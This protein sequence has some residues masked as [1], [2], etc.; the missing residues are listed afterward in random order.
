MSSTYIDRSNSYAANQQSFGVNSVRTSQS[1]EKPNLKEMLAAS[2]N[3]SA[4]KTPELVKPNSEPAAIF[5]MSRNSSAV[6]NRA[7]GEKLQKE[8]VEKTEERAEENQEKME[9][10]GQK[11]TQ[12]MEMVDGNSLKFKKHDGSGEIVM[13]LVDKAT[14]EEVR[15]VPSELF[16]NIASRFKEFLEQNQ[17]SA[18]AKEVITKTLEKTTQKAKDER[19]QAYL[20]FNSSSAV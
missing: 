12:L 13:V 8:M 3:N 17:Q 15:Q 20:N 14:E 1:A 9:E 19:A 7:E 18:E 16:L 6:K 11:M 5:E 2:T 10:L 4:K